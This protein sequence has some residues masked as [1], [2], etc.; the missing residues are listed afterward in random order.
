MKKKYISNLKKQ[1]SHFQLKD[2]E[3]FL[4]RRNNEIEIDLFS[5]LD[6]HF[7]KQV[8]KHRRN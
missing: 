4:G 3:N 5:L 6:P 2:Q 1:R 7:R 8:K